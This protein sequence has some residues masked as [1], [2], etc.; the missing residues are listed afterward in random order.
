MAVGFHSKIDEEDGEILRQYNEGEKKVIV[1]VGK[2]NEGVDMP[3]TNNVV[4]WR[5]T[6]SETVFKQQF[7]R[8]LR[9]D[10]VSVYDYVG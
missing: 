3:Q 9:G 1:A 2:L 4:F 8:G 5:D 7:G 10:K 6:E